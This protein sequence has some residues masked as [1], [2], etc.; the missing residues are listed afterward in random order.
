VIGTYRAPHLP[1]IAGS[2]ARLRSGKRC[3]T[4]H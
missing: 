1:H 2:T 4:R 3:L